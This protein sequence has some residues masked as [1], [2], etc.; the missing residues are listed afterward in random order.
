MGERGGGCNRYLGNAQ[1]EVMLNSKVLPLATP[2]IRIGVQED[3]F[4]FKHILQFSE[5]KSVSGIFLL[6][7]YGFSFKTA[8]NPGNSE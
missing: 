2:C 5:Y 1:I 6:Q 8:Q 4:V 3:N 7:F